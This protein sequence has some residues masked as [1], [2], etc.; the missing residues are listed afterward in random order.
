MNCTLKSI[1]SVQNNLYPSKMLWSI[2]NNL[3]RIEGQEKKYVCREPQHGGKNRSLDPKNFQFLGV[4]K[5]L[6]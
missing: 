4:K 2:Q 3:G 1:V 5:N 6:T